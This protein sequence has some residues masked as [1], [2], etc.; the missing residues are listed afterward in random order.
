[1]SLANAAIRKLQ[2]APFPDFVARPA[3]DSLVTEA[4]RRLDRD[5]P[6]DESAFAGAMALRAIA[7]HTTAANE[8]HYELPP[9]FF[10]ICLG[11]RLKYS[12]CLYPDA[13]TTLDEAEVA[14][15]VET[16]AHAD[17]A[18]GQAILEL[19]C[20]WGS[21]SLWMAEHYPRARITAVSNSHGQRGHI[22]AQAAARGLTNLTVIT[23]DM[24]D[25]DPQLAGQGRFDRIV[26]VEMFEHMANWR[27]LLERARGWLKTD[28]RMFIHVFTH[29]DAPYRFDH[30]DSGDFI[31]QHFF[32]GGIMPSR[33]LIRQFP[34]LFAVEEEWLWSGTHYQRT[35][36]DWLANMDANADRVMEL[37]QATYGQ[38]ASLWRRRWR[39]FYL[40]TAGLFGND[41]GRTWAV[42]HYRLKPA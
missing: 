2:D 24:N 4:R 33:G 17:L 30:T 18:D 7:E 29:R 20:G 6:H 31:A 8:Q 28:G 36:N 16:C 21:L 34:D 37:M 12:C 15:L 1:M 27:T 25:F 13:G 23:C 11:S 19:G 40:A 10:E 14:A 9:E 22:E 41:D 3:I 38:D 39:R 42:S 32:T 35:A 26:S 5:G